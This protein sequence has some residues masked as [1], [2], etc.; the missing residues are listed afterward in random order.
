[1]HNYNMYRYSV[2]NLAYYIGIIIIYLLYKRFEIRLLISSENVEFGYFI[3]Y[4]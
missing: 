2:V 4:N 1:M 3:K